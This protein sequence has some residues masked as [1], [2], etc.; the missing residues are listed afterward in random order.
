MTTSVAVVAALLTGVMLASVPVSAIAAAGDPCAV[1]G[2]KIACE[3]SKPG[4]DPSVW[5]IDGAGDESIQGFATD[6]SVNVGSRIDFKIDTDASNYSITI[7]RIGY[8]GGDGARQVATVSPS[9]TLPQRQPQ[10]ISDATTELYDCG[11]WAV[12]ASWNVPS[13]AVSGVY[14]AKLHR[15]DRNDSSHITFIVR[16]DSSH[17]DVVFQTSDPTWQAYNTYGGSDFYQ[18]ADNGRAYKISYNRPVMTRNG[19]GGRDFFFSN[20]YPLV[21]FLEQNGYDVSYIAGVDTDRAGA[22]LKNHKVFLSVGHDEYWSKAQRANVEAARDA[23]VNLQFLSGNEVYWKTRYESSAD[24]SHTPYRTLVS[25]KET[26]SNA[27]IDPS[28]EWTGTWRDPRY[29]PRSKG[30]GMTENG[31][32]GTAYMV[33]YSD[34]ALKVPAEQGKLRL[35]RNT[36]VANLAAGTTA[37]LAPH[38]VGY[39]SDEDLDNGERPAGLIRLSTTTGDVPEYL[40]DFGN[41]VAPG[42]TTHH[43]TMYRAPSGALVFGAGTVQW[44]WGLDGEHDS[45][46]A[47]EPADA[48]M[49]QAQVN[50]LADMG[51]QPFTLASGLTAATKSTD[52]A[53]P[54]VVISS[55]AAGAS[56]QNG[57]RITVTG[58]AADT[59]GR[60]AGVE[61]S[62]DGGSTWHP[63]TGTTAW[64]YTFIQ[65]GN[66][67]SPLRVRAID[68]SGNIG[69]PTD[70]SFNVACP[71]SVFGATVPAVPASDDA[72]SAELGLRFTPTSSGFVSGV[73]F[74]KGSGN[75][76]THVGSLWSSSAELLASATFSNESATGWQS[77]TFGTPVPVTAGQTYV[78]SYTVPNGHY[79]VQPWAFSSSPTDAGPLMVDGG[80][81]A[82]PAGVYGNAGQFPS[83]SYQNAN[84]FVDVSFTSTDESPLIATNQ[85]PLAGSSSVALDTTV[86]ARLSKPVVASSVGIVVKDANGV[87][88]AGSTAY[89]ATTR[90]VTFTPSQPLAG[91]VKFTSTVSA[92]DT[93]GNQVST[94]RTWSFTT[95]RPPNAPGVCPCSLFDDSTV[96]TLLEDVDKAAVTLGVKVSP[97]VNGTITGVR[98][99]KGLNNTG[100]HTGTLWSSTGQV[101]AQGTFTDES[102]TGWQ[103]LTFAQ[104]VPVTKGST[105]VAS[106]RTTVGRYSATPNAFANANLSRPPLSVTSS[107]GA[108]TYGTGFPDASSSTSYLVD[109]VFEKVAPTLAVTA[110]DPAPGATSVA[111][112]TP[113]RVWF[114]SAITSGATMTVKSG[115]TTIA[116]TTSLG[117]GGTQLTFTPGALL[118]ASSTITVTLA[119][120][121]STE[122]VT[123]PQQTWSFETR[124]ADAANSQSLFSDLLPEVAAADEGSPVELGTVV[125]PS[126]DGKITAIRFFKGTGNNGTHTGS[127][128]SMSGD[129]LA[130]VTFVGESPS[131]WQTANLT[132]PLSVTAGTSYVVS[133]LAPQGHYSYTS[134]FFNNPWTSGDLTSPSGNNGRYLYGDG[135]GF[136]TFSWGSSNYFVD[137][138]FEA[139]PATI[140]VASRTPVAGAVDVARTVTPSI[141]LSAPVAPGWSMSVKQ[142]TT[143]IAGTASLS[144]DQTK[145]TFT[146]TS[147]LPAGADITVTVSGV[148]STDGAVLATQTWTFRT[149]A[150]APSTY[151]S[152]FTGL[153]PSKTSIND[154]DA[155]E[156]GT[157]FTPSVDGTVTAIKFFKGSGNT[158]THTGSIW[159]ATG[160]RLATVTFTN[161]SSS[162]WQTAQLSTPLALTAGQTYVVSYFAPNGHYSGTPRFFYDNLTS[163]PLFAPGGNNGRFTY[164]AS[165]GF[166]TSSFNATNYFVDVVFRSS[167][168]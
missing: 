21:R 8:Y 123:L 17:S 71:C 161:E 125:T 57:S 59:G 67:T 162:G 18:G 47:P 45:P 40:L 15:S 121:T 168:P 65:H 128:W 29:A 30:G 112:G 131:G 37:T 83:Q 22:L 159:S 43:L 72:S 19:V 38:T 53:G 106:Y 52:T 96:P 42:S 61:A 27:K 64:S 23:G 101:L 111:R 139:A 24:S 114:S 127:V 150:S 157:A 70:R 97:D 7:Y 143:T 167:A 33:N 20:E 120:V 1:G 100:T 124:G 81:G 51:A 4:T 36:S 87:A 50:L 60:V 28:D 31:L 84:Y 156:L 46:F 135:G 140:A 154:K 79:A 116:G 148:V 41:N 146:P 85:W 145:L 54:T 5:D 141:T 91:F 75:T 39:E 164:G 93:L 138:V 63:A 166:P 66:G 105:Y 149:E 163:G 151:T 110:Q 136:P 160:T 3:N 68:D 86:S 152:L 117:S 147:N 95:A 74:Y 10:C 153:T 32:T 133:Y 126:K 78:V 89:D 56:Q 122:G 115:S 92:T 73:R 6:I 76:G 98:F 77:V 134:G 130:T 9:A 90:T 26:W 119:G 132:Q 25:Y 144:A 34:L 62:T 44:T 165:G 2:N 12:S 11:N 107:A 49:R 142:G 13:T 82:T 129:R 58:T 14:V 109:V 102:T 158:G 55:P 35:W 108:Y 103:T 94:G 104:P 16:D 80:F 113:I 137:V 155:V 118:P 69:A 48:R 88:V 99:Y